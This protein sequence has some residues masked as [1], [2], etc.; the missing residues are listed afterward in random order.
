M[1]GFKNVQILVFKKFLKRKNFKNL[2]FRL[3]VT[4]ENC[5]LSAELVVFIAM[6]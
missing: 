5:C 3:T 4:A 6:L 2:H 1:M